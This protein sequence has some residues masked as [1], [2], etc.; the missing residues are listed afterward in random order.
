MF[1]IVLAFVISAIISYL[2]GCIPSAYMVG[3]AF[4]GVDIRQIGSHNMGAMNTFYTIGFWP[5]MLVLAID[6][7]KGMLALTLSYLTA[8]FLLVPANLV[9]PVEMVSGVFVIAGH[10]FPVFLKFKG[11]KGGATAIGIL[12]FLLAWVN[13]VD[14]GSVKLPLPLGDLIYLGLFLLLMLITRWPTGSYAISFIAFWLI[15]W[16]VYQDTGLF[17]YAIFITAVPVLMYIPR[18]KEI[19]AK[20]GKNL[21]RG[22]FRR[23]LKDRL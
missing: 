18:I 13:W 4:K 17:I 11:G 8:M 7:S 16:F 14:I 5:G 22:I 21:I 12:A 10:N 3:R 6:V 20:S 15:A 19:W 2:L 1:N 9:V 23:N